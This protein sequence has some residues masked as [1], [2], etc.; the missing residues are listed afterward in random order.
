M[1]FSRKEKVKK[2][3]SATQRYNNYLRRYKWASFLLF[4]IGIFNFA[5]AIIGAIDAGG[6]SWPSSGYSFSLGIITY[7]NSLLY[8]GVG[9]LSASLIA[10]VI[11]ALVGAIF[12]AMGIFAKKGYSILLHIGTAIYMI[13]TVFVF[14]LYLVIPNFVSN[15][16]SWYDFALN[17]FIHLFI[18]CCLIIAHFFLFKIKMMLKTNKE[19]REIKGLEE[20]E[21]TEVIAENKEIEDNKEDDK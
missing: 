10:L 3:I 9:A 6:S 19:I 8:E 21:N 1:S 16:Y 13:D 11:S 17:A 2:V 14:I 18:L 20:V 15:Y 7:T 12:V 5:S 4:W